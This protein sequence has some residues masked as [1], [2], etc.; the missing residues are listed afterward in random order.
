MI[1]T[2]PRYCTR[3]SIDDQVLRGLVTAE[4]FTRFLE[5]RRRLAKSNL[6]P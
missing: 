1:T 4:Q 5:I 6:G 3:Q 2:F